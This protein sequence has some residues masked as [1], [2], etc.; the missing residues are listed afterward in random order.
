MYII[1]LLLYIYVHYL[2]IIVSYLCTFCLLLYIPMY[3]IYLFIYLLSTNVYIHE[4]TH[5]NDSKSRA[6]LHDAYLV[7]KLQI[8]KTT[9]VV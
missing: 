1:C 4:T 3:I 5:T 8:L 2:F 9:L 6:L 7:L